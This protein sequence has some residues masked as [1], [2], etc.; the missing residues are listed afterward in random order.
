MPARPV[1]GTTYTGHSHSR[2]DHAPA[3]ANRN[4]TNTPYVTVIARYRY[5]Y[6]R[7]RPD[8]PSGECFVWMSMRTG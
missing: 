7:L 4:A 6:R 1:S 8:G 5:R 2:L 3:L